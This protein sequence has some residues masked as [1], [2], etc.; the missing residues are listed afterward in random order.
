[1]PLT[2]AKVRLGTRHVLRQP[3][4]V[5]VRDEAISPPVPHLHRHA[6]RLEL[7]PPRRNVRNPIVPPPLLSGSQAVPDTA[8]HVAGKLAREDRSVNV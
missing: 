2:V 1:M 5:L 4:A 8:D 7:E 3:L 6:D